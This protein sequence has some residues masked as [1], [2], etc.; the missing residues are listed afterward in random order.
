M[1]SASLFLLTIVG[2]AIAA[3]V[4][5]SDS[6]VTY[7]G[8][9][10][11][12]VETFFAIPYGQDTG[13]ANR[14]KAPKPFVPAPGS[15]ISAQSRGPVCPQP[16]GDYAYPLY[17]SN[18]TEYSEDCL[19][20]NI[21]RPKGTSPHDSLPVMLHI[22][23]GSFFEGSKDELVIQPEGLVLRSVEMEHPIMFVTINYRLGGMSHV[24]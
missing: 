4:Y 3:A 21:Y 22:H 15:T 8:V 17:L 23:G 2:H 1:K 24:C 12:G 11:K 13:G 19:H 14:F 16:M 10:Q 7:E 18:V 6:D 20:L 9:F 5:N